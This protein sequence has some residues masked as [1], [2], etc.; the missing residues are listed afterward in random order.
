MQ[1]KSSLKQAI[2][3]SAEDKKSNL[4]RNQKAL[5]SSIEI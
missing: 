4:R 1:K 2:I 5:A 3:S